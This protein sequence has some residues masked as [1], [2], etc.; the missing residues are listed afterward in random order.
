MLKRMEKKKSKMRMRR[1]EKRRHKDDGEETK[2][3]ALYSRKESLE[4]I[5]LG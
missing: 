2:R 3:A 1:G 4:E 5:I